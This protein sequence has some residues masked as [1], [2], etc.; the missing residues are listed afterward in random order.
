MQKKALKTG[1]SLR[2]GPLGNLEEGSST[3]DFERW[4]KGA[5]GIV[6]L[7]LKRLRGGGSGGEASSLGTLEDMLR[8][9]PDMGISVH[10]G[11]FPAERNLESGG[12]SYTGDFER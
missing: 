7:S 12:G 10:G 4:M 2:R 3:G 11:P 8:K 1:V 9:S 5:L 6:F